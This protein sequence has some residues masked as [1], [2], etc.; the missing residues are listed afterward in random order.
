MTD[1]D[2]D[3]DIDK[4]SALVIDGNPTSRS[5]LSAQLR[6][7]GVGHVKQTGRVSEARLLLEHKPYEI[8]LCEHHF[9]ST[10]MSGQDLLD[11]L[12]REN[13]LPHSTVFIMVTSEATYAKVVEAAESALDSYLIKPYK[14][15]A[16][17]ERVFE[18]RRR[19]RVLKSVFEAMEAH[20]HERTLRLCV[21][22]FSKR[23]PYWQFCAR[24]AAELM[25]KFERPADARR[26]FEVV[27]K[28]SDKA[29]WAR[30][31]MSRALLAA[32]EVAQARR[33]VESLIQGN[34]MHADAFDVLG[35]LQVDQ[36]EFDAALD[37]FR[38]ASQLTPGCLLRLQHCGTLAFYQ[39]HTDEAVR[40]LERTAVLG[41]RSKLFDALTLVLLALLRYDDGDSKGLAAA[42]EQIRRYGERHPQDTGVACYLEAASALRAM[43]ARDMTAGV[44]TVRRMASGIETDSFAVQQATVLLSLLS[45]VPTTDMP[46]DEADAIARQAGMRFCVSKAVTEML[47]AAVGTTSPLA[48]TVRACHAQIAGMAQEAMNYSVRGEPRLAV[49]TLLRQ[50][51]DTRNAKLIE[52]AGLVAKRHASLIEDCADL[53]EQASEMQARLCQPIT[54]LAGVRRTGRSPGGLVLRS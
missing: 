46:A 36:G 37:T 38:S 32:G 25:L 54:H 45:R 44:E 28:E 15:S 41:L 31:G 17:G 50:G 2:F 26:I 35:S 39:G 33:E 23:E 30:L 27:A 20:D 48:A 1:A 10:D 53:L 18:A 5:V 24:V 51:A 22:R 21:Q 7:L 19:K 47:V 9:D 52:M 34:P 8:V 14:A 40:L 43:A 12:R 49:T 13:L 11:E 6:E 29:L 4:A 3:T 16:L 42:H